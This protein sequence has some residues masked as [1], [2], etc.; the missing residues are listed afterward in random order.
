MNIFPQ[1]SA[2]SAGP[3]LN[4]PAADVIEQ[5]GHIARAG[6]VISGCVTKPADATDFTTPAWPVPQ[7]VRAVQMRVEPVAQSQQLAD[8]PGQGGMRPVKEHIAC[9]AENTFIGARTRVAH[10]RFEPDEH[11]AFPRSARTFRCEEKRKT[12]VEGLKIQAGLSVSFWN[13]QRKTPVLPLRV[14]DR[15]TACRLSD[16]P[17]V[18]EQ[19][20]CVQGIIT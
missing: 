20:V 17:S 12:T 13:S 16:Q 15:V 14:D 7:P 4:D 19:S 10:L 3:P 1:N 2:G 6:H 5:P 9:R 8:L 18:C 11:R